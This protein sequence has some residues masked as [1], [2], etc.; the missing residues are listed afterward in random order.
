[1]NEY[2]SN[3]IFDITK[4]ISFVILLQLLNSRIIFPFFFVFIKFAQKKNLNFFLRKYRTDFQTYT[5][6]KIPPDF[7]KNLSNFQM[8]V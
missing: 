1:M 6:N 4:K 5:L 3:R 7:T 2:D 8:Y